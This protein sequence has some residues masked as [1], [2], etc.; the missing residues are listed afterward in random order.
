MQLSVSN[1]EQISSKP[2]LRLRSWSALFPFIVVDTNVIRDPGQGGAMNG[3]ALMQD[4]FENK[5]AE[6]FT[7]FPWTVQHIQF[8]NFIIAD[9]TFSSN[10]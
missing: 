4:G 7:K 3:L 6:I 1:Q 9:T 10:K 5:L 2:K 8:R